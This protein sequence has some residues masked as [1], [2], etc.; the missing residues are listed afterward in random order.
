MIVFAQRAA[1]R[2]L[3]WVL[4]AVVAGLPHPR[5]RPE[6]SSVM[7]AG[8]IRADG[9]VQALGARGAAVKVVR[10]V[11]QPFLQAAAGWLIQVYGVP[12]QVY[13]YA[14]EA[15]RLRDSMAVSADGYRVSRIEVSWVDRP[16]IWAEG[17]LLVVYLGR[18]QAMTDLLSGVLGAPIT[19]GGGV[20]ALRADV[21]H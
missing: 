21:P 10:R 18:N 17:N 8:P 20:P 15:E 9:L 19:E 16:N 2:L 5:L 3:P 1:V 4:V 7:A 12:V 13:E 14:T 11:E 6:A